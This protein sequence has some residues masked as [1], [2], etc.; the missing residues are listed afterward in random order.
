[1]KYEGNGLS[2]WKVKKSATKNYQRKLNIK[3]YQACLHIKMLAMCFMRCA[4]GLLHYL[5]AQYAFTE[6]GIADSNQTEN[7]PTFNWTKYIFPRRILISKCLVLGVMYK[8]GQQ[9]GRKC[10]IVAS[11]LRA[12]QGP[13]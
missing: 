9:S 13:V 8:G 5:P 2:I 1:M 7:C 6:A 11:A 3:E 10:V 4:I 12:E